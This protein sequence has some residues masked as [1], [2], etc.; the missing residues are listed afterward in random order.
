M[1]LPPSCILCPSLTRVWNICQTITVEYIPD[2]KANISTKNQTGSILVAVLIGAVVILSVGFYGMVVSYNS[3]LTSPHTNSTPINEQVVTQTA[4]PVPKPSDRALKAAAW[5]VAH[6]PESQL[7]DV[8]NKNPNLGSTSAEVVKSMATYY[9]ANPE[10]LALFEAEIEKY[11]LEQQQS[12][13]TVI[14]K[15]APSLLNSVRCTSNTIGD[16]T[17]TNCY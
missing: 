3:Q 13:Q 6:T 11:N 4:S 9:D 8:M 12:A 14:Y 5:L 17:Y 7:N 16:Y 15:Q 2:F 10:A 1:V